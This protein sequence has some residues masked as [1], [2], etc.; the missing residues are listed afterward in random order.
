MKIISCNVQGAKQQLKAEMS[1]LTWTDKPNVLIF[2]EK[3]VNE[4]NTKQLI[5]KLGFE[6]EGL[7]CRITLKL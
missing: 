3:M 2:P 5:S 7:S 4:H 1:L 6:M